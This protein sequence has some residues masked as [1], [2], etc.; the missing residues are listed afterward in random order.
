M[1][2]FSGLLKLGAGRG[3]WNVFDMLF[4]R[5]GKFKNVETTYF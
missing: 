2:V 1:A 4:V 3:W 5:F